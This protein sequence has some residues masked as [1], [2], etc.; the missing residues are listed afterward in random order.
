[1]T[2]SFLFCGV[3]GHKRISLPLN[4]YLV[5]SSSSRSRKGITINDSDA[6]AM[7]FFLDRPRRNLWKVTHL[8]EDRRDRPTEI[9]SSYACLRIYS[10]IPLRSTIPRPKTTTGTNRLDT[11]QRCK[12]KHAE[13]RR[14]NAKSG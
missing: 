6:P 8:E 7:F 2:V 4:L 13:T 14:S 11:V 5:I 10:N 12:A 3:K 1:M 9:L